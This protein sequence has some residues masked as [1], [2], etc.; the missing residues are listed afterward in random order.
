MKEQ[1]HFWEEKSTFF[2]YQTGKNEGQERYGYYGQIARKMMTFW[3]MLC[4]Y[5]LKVK[6]RFLNKN[7]SFCLSFVLRY[8]LFI[9]ININFYVEKLQVGKCL[10]YSF[11]KCE[12]N[13]HPAKSILLV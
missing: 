8:C 10:F 1:S 9:I 6:F 2:P 4:L 13:T 3:L 12:L 11:K 7:L 5:F